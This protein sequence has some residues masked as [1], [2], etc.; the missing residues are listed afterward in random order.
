MLTTSLKSSIERKPCMVLFN[1]LQAGLIQLGFIHWEIKT[2]N[3]NPMQSL[4]WLLERGLTAGNCP[5]VC[6]HLHRVLSVYWGREMGEISWSMLQHTDTSP[7]KREDPWALPPGQSSLPERKDERV[8][9]D[10]KFT[11]L[12]ATSRDL[13]ATGIISNPTYKAV[14]AERCH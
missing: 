8:C 11:S 6:L 5:S 10:T 4:L 13:L 9:W 7:Q 12:V 1:A 14:Q 3:G 2:Y